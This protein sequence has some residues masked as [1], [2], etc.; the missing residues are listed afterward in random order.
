MYDRFI[1][2]STIVAYHRLKLIFDVLWGA[3]DTAVA[4]RLCDSGNEE[5]RRGYDGRDMLDLVRAI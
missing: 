1:R 4:S 5:A 3:R 2:G